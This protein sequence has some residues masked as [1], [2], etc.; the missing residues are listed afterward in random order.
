MS[1][2]YPGKVPIVGAPE[3]L[4]GTPVILSACFIAGWN[5]EK[6]RDAEYAGDKRWIQPH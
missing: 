6:R 2:V 5:A 1:T 3:V 4:T